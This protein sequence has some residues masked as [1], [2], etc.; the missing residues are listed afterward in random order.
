MSMDRAL[1]E[2]TVFPSTEHRERLLCVRGQ[3]NERGY[4]MSMDIALSRLLGIHGQI[5]VETNVCPWT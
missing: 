4:C 5:I 3:N 2:A 1:G